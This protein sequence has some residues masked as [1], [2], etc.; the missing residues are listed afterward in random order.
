MEKDITFASVAELSRMLAAREV[1]AVELAQHYLARIEAHK[2]LNAFLDVR[3]E[4]T[5]EQARQADERI[6]ADESAGAHLGLFANHARACDAGRRRNRR[7][8][9]DPHI[10]RRMIVSAQIERSADFEHRFADVGKRFPRI[11]ARGK[12]LFRAGMR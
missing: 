1:S 2:D 10:R 8:L 3:P 9:G 12:H 7:R 6:A 11:F 5:L 4:A